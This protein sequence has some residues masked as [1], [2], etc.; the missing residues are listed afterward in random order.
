[1]KAREAIIMNFLVNMSDILVVV[2]DKFS[3]VE[4][5]VVEKIRKKIS[6]NNYC[7]LKE[8]LVIHNYHDGNLYQDALL[9][10]KF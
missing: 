4:R 7:G 1:M 10:G 9:M 2:I 6:S 3:F 8:L 5:A